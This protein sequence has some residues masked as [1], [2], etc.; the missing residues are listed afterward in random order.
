MN[1]NLNNN[2][3]IYNQIK[4]KKLIMLIIYNNFFLFFI[5]KNNILKKN[6]KLKIIL[7]LNEITY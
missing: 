4:W 7:N 3:F 5:T 1:K 6:K 2:V